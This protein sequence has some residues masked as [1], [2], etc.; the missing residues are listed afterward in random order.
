MMHPEKVLSCILH[1][2][3]TDNN[4]NMFY[5]CRGSHVKGFGEKGMIDIVRFM[6]EC[7][8]MGL[9]YWLYKREIKTESA[10]EELKS[11]PHP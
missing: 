3:C 1:G 9:W 10:R 5:E 2:V 6:K 11:R 4:H 7:G 8:R